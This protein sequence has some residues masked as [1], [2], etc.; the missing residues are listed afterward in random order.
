MTQS[1]EERAEVR[2]HSPSTPQ[3]VSAG[4]PLFGDPRTWAA[5]GTTVVQLLGQ[6]VRSLTS[7]P[8]NILHMAKGKQKRGPL[9]NADLT[10]ES[11]AAKE[12]RDARAGWGLSDQADQG[13][14]LFPLIQTQ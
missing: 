14:V 10:T 13:Q 5:V 1:P 12:G 3:W 6:R 9:G 7:V 11:Q 2:P 8:R 4:Y